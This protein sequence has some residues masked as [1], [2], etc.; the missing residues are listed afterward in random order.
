MVCE[1]PVM[2][3]KKSDMDHYICITM[4][5]AEYELLIDCGPSADLQASQCVVILFG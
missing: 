2:D 1:P 4:L 3:S 5:P